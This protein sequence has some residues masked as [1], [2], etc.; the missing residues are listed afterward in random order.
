MSEL[1]A[2]HIPMYIKS[3]GHT[4]AVSHAHGEHSETFC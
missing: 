2:I 1:N 3:H 4:L